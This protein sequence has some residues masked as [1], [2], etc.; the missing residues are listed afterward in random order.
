MR[1]ASRHLRWADAR[2][3]FV[4]A[5]GFVVW[6]WIVPAV[7]VAQI[8][9]HHTGFVAIRG[10]WVGFGSAGVTGLTLHEGRS[11]RSPVWATVPRVSTD[12]SLNGLLRG[13]TIPRRIWFRA[14]RIV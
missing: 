3:G 9:K 10:W 5:T 12:L 4:L 11:P 14:S 7:I 1:K 6:A 8:R 13:R 2:L